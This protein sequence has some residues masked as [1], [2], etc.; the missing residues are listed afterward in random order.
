MLYFL[1]MLKFCKSLVNNKNKN[2]YFFM[3]FLVG[4]NVSKKEFSV[5]RIMEYIIEVLCFFLFFNLLKNKFF[6]G[7]MKNFSMKIKKVEISVKVGLFV[8]VNFLVK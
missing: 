5:I 4:S 2:V 6:K 3:I 7:R 8:W 1:F